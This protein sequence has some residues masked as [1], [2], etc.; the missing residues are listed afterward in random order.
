MSHVLLSG[1]SE[2]YPGLRALLREWGL[3]VG[4]RSVGTAPVDVGSCDVV[5]HVETEGALPGA[6]PDGAQE[7]GGAAGAAPP[8]S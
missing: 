6:M 3:T 7:A 2:R 4:D 8:A 5:L 1:N